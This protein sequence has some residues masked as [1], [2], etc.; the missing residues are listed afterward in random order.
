MRFELLRVDCSVG[1]DGSDGCSQ[2]VRVLLYGIYHSARGVCHV[3]NGD[4]PDIYPGHREHQCTDSHI[5]LWV[6]NF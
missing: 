3:C 4:H 6:R 1:R 2:D 5:Y